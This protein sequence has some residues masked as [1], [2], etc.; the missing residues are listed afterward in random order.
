MPHTY[1]ELDPCRQTLHFTVA[2]HEL[3]REGSVATRREPAH[4]PVGVCQHHGRSPDLG[5][6]I[7][8]RPAAARIVGGAAVQGHGIGH[9][10]RGGAID[11]LRHG[12]KIAGVLRRT[13]VDATVHDPGVPVGIRGRSVRRIGVARIDTGRVHP[14]PIVAPGRIDEQRV[15]GNVAEGAGCLDPPCVGAA[16]AVPEVVECDFIFGMRALAVQ[17]L[18]PA[19]LAEDIVHNPAMS[20]AN[21][22]DDVDVA[23][24]IPLVAGQGVVGQHAAVDQAGAAARHCPVVVDEVVRDQRRAAL[25][26]DGPSG[27]GGVAAQ[28]VARDDCV[29]VKAADAAPIVAGAIRPTDHG[30]Q[31][32]RDHVQHDGRRG[33]DAENPA[34]ERHARALRKDGA[35]AAGDREAAEHRRPA[36]AVDEGDHGPGR[37]P[38]FGGRGPEDRRR[39]DLGV[40]RVL[41]SNHEVLAA[42]NDAFLVGPR[43]DDDGIP[44]L[45]GVDGRLDARVL[46]RDDN[47][48]TASLAR[49]RQ[50]QRHRE[51]PHTRYTHLRPFLPDR[52]EPGYSVTSV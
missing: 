41:A 18:G 20:I 49:P 1:H 33:P 23:A 42:K 30:Y 46:L 8:E 40:I 9:L 34:A 43:L 12:S 52:P 48:S 5:P 25:D 13:D 28:D 22:C 51:D 21:T 17:S 3:E 32:P 24:G 37:G 16:G 2:D 14:Q 15:G 11:D 27:V 36:L 26:E 31:V 39:D 7:G 38:A 50:H 47:G 4:R 35:G 44:I 45:A 29:R 6:A 19:G 10:L